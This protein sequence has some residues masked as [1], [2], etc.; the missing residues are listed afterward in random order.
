MLA[1]QGKLQEEYR[2]ALDTYL[3]ALDGTWFHSSEQVHCDQCS[4]KEHRDGRTT[5][6]HSAITPVFVRQGV[7]RVVAAEPEFIRPQ[8]GQAKQ[9]CEINAAK[10]WIN[11]VGAKYSQ[12]GV[13]L[14]G[15]D[16]YAK[17]PFC[18]EVSK[19]G[20]HYLFTCKSSSHLYLYEWI[21]ATEVGLD[22][23]EVVYKRWTGKEHMYERYRF[24]NTVPIR[25]GTDALRVNWCE[26]LLNDCA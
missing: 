26:L 6:Y 9:D 10:R 14:L 22:I 19:S 24:I 1:D 5:Y 12:L 3:I 17:Q 18:S 25:D 21:D 2:T 7:N 20:F 13:T 23:T 4:V 15:D 8:D 16:P 11:G